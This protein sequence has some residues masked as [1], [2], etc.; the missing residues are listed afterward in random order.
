MNTGDDYAIATAE[1]A[2]SQDVWII[3]EANNLTH[4]ENLWNGDPT[5]AVS[6]DLIERVVTYQ[7]SGNVD[8]HN[9]VVNLQFP[10]NVDGFPG[11]TEYS[12][13]LLPFGSEG[14][15]VVT[16]Y[17]GPQGFDPITAIGRIW[18]QEYGAVP[19]DTD[20]ATVIEK[21]LQCHDGYLTED[22]LCDFDSNG[23]LIGTLLPGQS[24][25]SRAGIPAY[26]CEVVTE[27]IINTGCIDYSYTLGNGTFN[28]GYCVWVTSDVEGPMCRS[29]T[30]LDEVQQSTTGWDVYFSCIGQNTTATTLISMDCGNGQYITGYGAS[31]E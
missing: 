19:A 3:V 20:D 26:G 12:F 29:V 11:L 2:A 28:G 24:C 14:S 6:G 7:N 15:F 1:I 25:Q 30:V 27:Y 17:V 31:L 23:N 22:E 10:S 21:P 5:W 8:L 16:G 18:A 4:M 9:V 13:D